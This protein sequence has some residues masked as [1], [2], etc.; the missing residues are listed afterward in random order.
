MAKVI[1]FCII[2]VFLLF[3]DT[4]A[5]GKR[6]MPADIYRAIVKLLDG[7]CTAKVKERTPA[8]RAAVIRLWRGL[9]TF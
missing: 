3:S 2:S 9:Y 1:L 7:S 8:Q 4:N 6:P 5:Y